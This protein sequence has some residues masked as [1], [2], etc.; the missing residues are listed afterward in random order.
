MKRLVY[1]VL[2]A[3]LLF[4]AGAYV[5]WVGASKVAY[6]K[7]V[8]TLHGSRNSFDYISESGMEGVMWFVCRLMIDD[9][10]PLKSAPSVA[11]MRDLAKN[12]HIDEANLIASNGVIIASNL[13]ELVGFDM[14]PY[15]ELKPILDLFRSDTEDYHFGQPFRTSVGSREGKST[16]YYSALLPDR[17]RVLEIGISLEHY[18]RT[19]QQVGADTYHHWK[20]GQ[21]GRFSVVDRDGDGSTDAVA[22]W[23]ELP[24]EGLLSEETL[25]G[26]EEVFSLVFPYAGLVYRAVVP[27]REYYEQRNR[28]VLLAYSVAGV[29]FLVLVAFAA[30]I[31][32]QTER[33]NELHRREEARAAQELASA[34]AIQLSS[35]QRTELFRIES[36]DSSFAAVTYPAREV[37]GDLYG[38]FELSDGRVAFVVGDVSGKGVPAA[39]FMHIAKN[40]FELRLRTNSSLVEA[41][42]QSNAH[43]CESNRAEMFVTAWFGVF[44]PKSGI[45]EYVNAGHNRP[46]VLR[47]N[48]VVE[49]VDGRGGLFLGTFPKATYEANRLRLNR[50]ERLFVYTDGVTE[51]MDADKN[52]YGDPRLVA[53]L[54]KHPKDLCKAVR[55]DVDAFVGAVERSDDLTMLT[56]AYYGRP[57]E[58]EQEF[59]A[60]PDVLAE[61]VE[62]VR[63]MVRFQHKKQEARLIN[64]VDEVLANVVNYSGATTVRIKVQNVP[65]RCG[66]VISDT[67]TPYDPLTHQDPNIHASL[68]NRPIGGLGILMVKKLVDSISYGRADGRNVLTLVQIDFNGKYRQVV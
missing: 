38:V 12:H 2:G 10:L 8:D 65:G 60:D 49:R 29:F 3:A 27:K 62:F 43:L 18:H 64:A 67:G 42:A 63:G 28:V 31:L 14:K 61:M 53:C 4:A 23:P 6:Q 47:A 1:L 24:A 51:A 32:A 57:E 33:L 54:S 19:I 39:M 25:E 59:P 21:Y 20:I 35:L 55:A 30:K 36:F 45:V 34:R 52:L 66:V 17:T 68:Q 50:G 7:S 48:G 13:G 58:I 46:Y 11:W 41:V 15:P 56:L 40:A 5:L 37:G 16:K 26:G 44:D 22:Q 9:V